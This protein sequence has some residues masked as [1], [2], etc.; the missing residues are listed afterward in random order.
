[1]AKKKEVGATAPKEEEFG[2]S[3]TGQVYKLNRAKG[4]CKKVKSWADIEM[5]V[6]DVRMNM[7]PYQKYLKAVYPDEPCPIKNGRLMFRGFRISCDIEN[8]FMIEDTTKRYAV[9]ETN[10]EEGIPTPRELGDFFAHK[11]VEVTPEDAGAAARRGKE[12]LEKEKKEMERKFHKEEKDENVDY[13]KLRKQTLKLIKKVQDGNLKDFDPASLLEAIPFKRW[14]RKVKALYKQWKEK[15]IRYPKFLKE[16]GQVT[17]EETFIVEEKNHR[18]KFVGTVPPEYSNVGMLKGDKLEVDGKLV[19]AVPFL[20]EY[21]LCEEPKAMPQL[22]KFAQ[23]EITAQEWVMNPVVEDWKVEYKRHLLKN[24]AENARLISC[25]M[26]VAGILPPQDLLFEAD[27]KVGDKIF[28]LVDGEWKRR[29]I[30]DVEK[31]IIIGGG[32][33]LTKFDKWIKIEQ[34]SETKGAQK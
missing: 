19:D 22:M 23:G 33:G 6:S 26:D 32:V 34:E 20:E 24:T 29:K 28:I 10:F 30:C 8:G 11:T 7:T 12:L 17:E 27:V 14:R 21:F 3:T 1:M 25:A 16:V 5:E 2:T 15:K 13:E 4:T 31:G 18:M 9:V